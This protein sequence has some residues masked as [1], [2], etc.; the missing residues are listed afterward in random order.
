MEQDNRFLRFFFATIA[1]TFL[2]LAIWSYQIGQ[3]DAAGVASAG[4]LIFLLMWAN[5]QMGGFISRTRYNEQRA[6]K[7]QQE[8]IDGRL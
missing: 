2:G 7:E 5:E 1:S 4:A 3:G 6:Q 8:T